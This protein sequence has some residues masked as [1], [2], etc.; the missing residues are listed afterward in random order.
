MSRDLNQ[1]RL[2]LTPALRVVSDQPAPAA[3]PLILTQPEAEPPVDPVPEPVWEDQIWPQAD[4]PLAELALG[5]EEAE[6]VAHDPTVWP[7]VEAPS[8]TGP[9]PAA[10]DPAPPEDDLDVA[11]MLTAAVVEDEG[12]RHLTEDELQDLVRVMVRQEL[13]GSLGERITRNV[14]KLVRAEINRALAA[15]ALD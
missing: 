1:D 10:N 15:Q 14:R 3:A 12:F 7:E 4:A 9:G 2:L 5:A 8:W 11:E 6:L 13:Q